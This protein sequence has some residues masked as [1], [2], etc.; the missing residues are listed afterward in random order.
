M[1]RSKRRV[2]AGGVVMTGFR[3]ADPGE[4]AAF[5][6]QLADL[7]LGGVILFDRDAG[8]GAAPRNVRDPA[9][10][11]ELIA[12]LRAAAASPLVVAVDQEGGAV[13]RLHPGNGFP[14]TPSPRDTASRRVST[15]REA[16]GVIARSLASAGVDLNLA[17]AVD[18]ALR[19]DGPLA[20]RGR[21]YGTR[22]DEVIRHARA[23]LSEHRL[24][25]VACALKHFPGLG[26][27][28][29]D[30][31]RAV[32]DVT[33]D[34][35]PEELEP[36]RVLASEPASRAVLLAHAIHG[37]LDPGVPASLS[38][39]WVR[40]LREEI[41][42]DGVVVVG[43]PKMLPLLGR[44]K[45]QTRSGG[46]GRLIGPERS[47]PGGVHGFAEGSIPPSRRGACCS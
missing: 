29:P 7:R 13:A 16:A 31:H 12:S 23:F 11:R 41:G 17:P 25:G 43:H 4:A 36:Y 34:H 2:L 42:F 20:A 22:A 37:G 5:L 18:L 10:L 35:R 6:E 33:A 21:L 1:D 28:R 40:L 39:A 32:A 30:T 45:A 9:S 24:A 15:T 19:P 27:A 46:D 14:A 3:G 44:E 38:A 8:P 47:G 26:S